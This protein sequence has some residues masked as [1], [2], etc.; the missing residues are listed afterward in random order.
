MNF[1]NTRREEVI[2]DPDVSVEDA[3]GTL[4]LINDM[5]T[6]SED[7]HECNCQCQE[8]VAEG[9]E[10]LSGIAALLPSTRFKESSR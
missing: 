7:I 10:T 8:C 1:F 9:Q 5:E 4:A 2:Q 3:L 6:T